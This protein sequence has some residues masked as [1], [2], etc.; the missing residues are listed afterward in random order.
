MSTELQTTSSG[1]SALYVVPA[2][3]NAIVKALQSPLVNQVE[4]K[5]VFAALNLAIGKAYADTGFKIVPDGA[6]SEEGKAAKV[7]YGNMIN[8]LVTY[9]K[10]YAATYRVNEIGIAIERGT[11]K[12]YGDYYGLNK[13]SFVQFI[14]GYKASE[15][16]ATAL[17]AHIAN[18]DKPKMPPTIEEQFNTAKEN[19]L[20]AFESHKSR[21]PIERLFAPA[22]DFLKELQLCIYDKEVRAEIFKTATARVIDEARSKKAGGDYFARQAISQLIEKFELQP[23]PGTKEFNIIVAKGKAITCARYF[24]DVLLV[25]EDLAGLIDGKKEFYLKLKA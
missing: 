7:L 19:T 12:E 16:R 18:Q 6:S 8:E 9:V 22:Y 20:Q 10:T 17:A 3:N 24:D 4:P 25:G 13:V 21:K 15:A 5:E 2:Q 11:Q 14:K 1:L 23:D